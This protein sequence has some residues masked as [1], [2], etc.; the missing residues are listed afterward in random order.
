MSRRGSRRGRVI[1]AIVFTFIAGVCTGWVMRAPVTRAVLL[2]STDLTLARARLQPDWIVKWLRDPQKLQPGTK[3]PT[4]Y[5]P[6]DPKGSTPPDVLDGDP[7]RQMVALRDY[8]YSIGQ[9]S[10]QR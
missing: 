1:P 7:D 10:R 4:F 9:G 2:R 8:I 3:M 6:A 5:D